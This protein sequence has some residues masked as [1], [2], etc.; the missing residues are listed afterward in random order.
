MRIEDRGQGLR[1]KYEQGYS[2]VWMDGWEA[3]WLGE[4]P[5]AGREMDITYVIT[6]RFG[7]PPNK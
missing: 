1:A 4:E 6:Q 5:R 3:C 2:Q 7:P